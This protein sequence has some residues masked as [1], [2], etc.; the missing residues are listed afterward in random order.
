MEVMKKLGK[1]LPIILSVLVLITGNC[2]FAIVEDAPSLSKKELKRIEKKK[3]DR[4]SV[5]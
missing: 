3:K 5:V 4:K 2:A 1:I